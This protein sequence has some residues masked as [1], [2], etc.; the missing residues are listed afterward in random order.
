MSNKLNSGSLDTLKVGDVLMK[1]VQTT[2]TGGYQVCFIENINRGGNAGSSAL[3][4]LNYSDSRFQRGSRMYVYATA[5]LSDLEKALGIDGLDIENM[6]F[7]AETTKSGKVINCATLNILNPVNVLNGKKFKVQIDEDTKPLDEWQA[8]NDAY[9]VNPATGEA[10]MK[11][12]Q[13]IYSKNTLTY[14]DSVQHTLIAH[15]REPV[16]AEQP[17]Q[18]FEAELEMI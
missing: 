5:Q 18:N 12:G 1:H 9:K 8:N 3:S 16:A 13:H 11:D 15:D 4:D 10:L 7:A 6:D 17:V 2:S 14:E